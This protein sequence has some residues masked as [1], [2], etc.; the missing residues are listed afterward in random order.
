[1]KT[2]KEKQI[3]GSYIELLKNSIDEKGI[4]P[5]PAMVVDNEGKVSMLSL[6]V[7]PD[8][9]YE[10]VRKVAGSE[11]KEILMGL[12]RTS[13]SGQGIPEEFDSVF[14]FVHIENGMGFKVGCLPYTGEPRNVG[15]VQW[16]NT[17]WNPIVTRD[18]KTFGFIDP[19]TTDEVI[20]SAYTNKLKVTHIR[21]T[22]SGQ[23]YEGIVDFDKLSPDVQEFFSETGL[24]ANDRKSV[25]GF[26]KD[27]GVKF[28]Y[29]YED[30]GYVTLHAGRGIFPA[31]SSKSKLYIEGIEAIVR[32]FTLAI[33]TQQQ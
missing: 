5:A 16:D 24:D 2:E 25:I 4:H 22:S 32:D 15:E 6:M 9:A 27:K 21:N 23:R 14:T 20:G 29:S 33:K 30:M 26:F 12:D 13:K 10:T 28:D 3:L 8:Q 19:E 31:R 17:F 7:E 18:L 11:Y 1:M